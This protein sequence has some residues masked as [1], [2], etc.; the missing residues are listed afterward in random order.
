MAAAPQ[1]AQAVESFAQKRVM[2]MVDAMVLLGIKRNVA[3]RT[4]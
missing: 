3:Q 2:G 4:R 1:R